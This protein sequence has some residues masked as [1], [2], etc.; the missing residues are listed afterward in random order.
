MVC[1]TGSD[2]RNGYQQYGIESR[3]CRSRAV[4]PQRVLDL[5][6]ERE[7]CTMNDSPAEQGSGGSR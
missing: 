4:L 6:G 1:A 5:A 2:E 7:I 3:K